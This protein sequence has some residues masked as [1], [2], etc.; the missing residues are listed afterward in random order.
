MAEIFQCE[1]KVS[2]EKLI[3]HKRDFGGDTFLVDDVQDIN[4]SGTSSHFHVWT[5]LSIFVKG[6]VTSMIDLLVLP[7]DERINLCFQELFILGVKERTR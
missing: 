6:G 5:L 3:R 4:E 2:V 7:S 1:P